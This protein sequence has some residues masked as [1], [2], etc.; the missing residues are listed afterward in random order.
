MKAQRYNEL[1]ERAGGDGQVVNIGYKSAAITVHGVR[2]T[3]RWQKEFAT[4]AGD[5]LI[6]ASHV[7]FGHRFPAL[8]PNRCAQDAAEQ[9]VEQYREHRTWGLGVAAIGHSFGTLVIGVALRSF[10]EL[11]FRRLI[12]SSSILACNFPWKDY[13]S[14]PR[15]VARVLNE[16]CPKDW[17]VPLSV[18]WRPFP[19]SM[20]T[21]RSGRRGFSDTGGSVVSNVRYRYVGHTRLPNRL[22]M[23][24]AWL[25]FLLAGRIPQG[26]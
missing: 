21:G 26:G 13:V 10:T 4:L 24:R 3:G 20:P 14:Q 18:V 12:L 9:L 25:P 16:Y 7:D 17:V 2:T 11:E 8:T 6:R 22:H 5:R 1:V 23:E 19:F 15:R